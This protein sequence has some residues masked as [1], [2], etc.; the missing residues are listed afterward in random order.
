M[1]DK[2]QQ[3]DVISVK[4]KLPGGRTPITSTA[5]SPNGKLIVGCE[6]L[7]PLLLIPKQCIAGQDGALWLW[8]TNS[9]FLKPTHVG[10][11]SI[12]SLFG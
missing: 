6:S 12:L 4:S 2:W 5:F 10:Q 3:K 9:A 1:N 11:L 8:N 7:L